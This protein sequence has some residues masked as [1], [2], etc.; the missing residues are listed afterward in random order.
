MKTER[1]AKFTAIVFDLS[2]NFPQLVLI[3]FLDEDIVTR[4]V[5]RFSYSSDSFIPPTQ[6][7]VPLAPHLQQGFIAREVFRLKYLPRV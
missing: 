4:K 7:A 3:N 2:E 6:I 5:S 1:L